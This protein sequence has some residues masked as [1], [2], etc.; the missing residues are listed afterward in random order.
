[1]FALPNQ[2][3]STIS[4]YITANVDENAKVVTDGGH[5]EL[6]KIKDLVKEH[7]P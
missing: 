7:V 3:Y 5:Y 4:P 6:I 1:M 2:H